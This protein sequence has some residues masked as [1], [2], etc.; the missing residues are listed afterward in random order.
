MMAKRRPHVR[1]LP[2]VASPRAWRMVRESLP[3]PAPL[4]QYSEPPMSPNPHPQCLDL[5]RLGDAPV[6]GKAEGLARLI[7]LGFDVPPGFVVVG[8]SPGHLP[9]DLADRY[10]ALGEGPVA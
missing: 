1:A 3:T 2:R 4:G 6:G 8:A 9:A 7:R 10:R 5:D